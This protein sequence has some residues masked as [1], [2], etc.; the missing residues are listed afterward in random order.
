[1]VP[2]Y[3]PPVHPSCAP[4][5]PPSPPPPDNSPH[6]TPQ[7]PRDTT[8][9]TGSDTANASKNEMICWPEMATKPEMATRIA[10]GDSHDHASPA[11][12][13]VLHHHP[14]LRHRGSVRHR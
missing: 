8:A 11:E 7:R 2:R 14:G 5:V 9:P 4:G 10:R 6:A 13:R 1:M 12:R 3:D